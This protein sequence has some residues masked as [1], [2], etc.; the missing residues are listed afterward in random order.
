MYIALDK[1]YYL[2]NSYFTM[3]TIHCNSSTPLLFTNFSTSIDHV[4]MAMCMLQ[5]LRSYNLSFRKYFCIVQFD[6]FWTIFAECFKQFQT[7][8]NSN[9]GKSSCASSKNI[10]S[11]SN[12]RKNVIQEEISSTISFRYSFPIILMG[13]FIYNHSP[14]AALPCISIIPKNLHKYFDSFQITGDK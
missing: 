3:N 4:K 10:F 1:C 14:L 6:L 2:L 12:Y 9:K 13:L 7:N 8:T 5:M 11:P